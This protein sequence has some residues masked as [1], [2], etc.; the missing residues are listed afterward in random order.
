MNFLIGVV[1]TNE[2][3]PTEKGAYEEC[4][5]GMVRRFIAHYREERFRRYTMAGVLLW[6]YGIAVTWFCID[7]VGIAGWLFYILITPVTFIMK[8][9][10]YDKFAFRKDERW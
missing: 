4:F 9:A 7:F 3:K 6:I 5:K 1:M 10:I 2:N 8:Y